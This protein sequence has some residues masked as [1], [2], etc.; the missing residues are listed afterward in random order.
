MKN[1]YRRIVIACFIVSVIGCV[2]ICVNA[3]EMVTE[4]EVTFKGTSAIP[5]VESGTAQNNYI[6]GPN[7]NDMK[8]NQ[9]IVSTGSVYDNVSGKEV[10]N[11]PALLPNTGNST[12]MNF[13]NLIYGL[14]LGTVIIIIV[15]K[16]K[17]GNIS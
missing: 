8:G 5:V 12:V 6:N 9:F 16:R 3:S 17:R 2:P 11:T 13:R 7:N 14:L 10:V 4:A 1:A 15:Q